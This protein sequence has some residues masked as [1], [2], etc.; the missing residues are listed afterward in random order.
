MTPPVRILVSNDD[1]IASEGLAA[2]A[3][4]MAPLGEVWVVA[5][6]REQSASSH[7]ISLN[8]PLRLHSVKERWYSVD[9]TPTD[10]SYLGIHHLLKDQ[11]PALMVSGI[12]HGA[13]LADDVS[14]SG[15]VAAAMEASL[16]GV[17]AIAFSLVARK[18]FDFQP[19]AR[20]ARALARAVLAGPRPQRLL[21][22]VNIPGPGEPKGF[23]LTRLGKHSYGNKVVESVDPRGRKYYWI[24]GSEYQHQSI[25][26]SDCNAVIDDRLISV[27]PLHLDLTDNGTLQQLKRLELDDFPRVD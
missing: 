2:L 24:G 17:P 6:D 22:N 5:P 21:L 18:T 26:G 19:A 8:R 3:A 11:A 7:A 4:A 12:N 14:Y 20:F 13:N 15:T 25:A 27:T 1:G 16:L 23:A 10:C 9:G